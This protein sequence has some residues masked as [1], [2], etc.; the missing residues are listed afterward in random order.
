MGLM[1]AGKSTVGGALALRLDCPH[2]DND[3]LL[4]ANAGATAAALAVKAGAE[5][6]HAQ[7][8]AQLRRMVSMP[9]PFVAGIAAS[10]ADRPDDLALL[11]AAGTV[12]YLRVSASVLAARLGPG[13]GRPWLNGDAEA[14]LQRM[15][16]QRDAA[17]QSC[18]DLVIDCD[19]ADAQ[20][21]ARDI[22]A[23][24][25]AAG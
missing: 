18:A 15:F 17:F 13:E 22:A 16:E 19:V 14:V 7:E 5:E 6:L 11:R 10:A 12:V 4:L 25:V 21:V 8:S 1:G 3:H 23:A 20:S 24:L 9:A 2:L